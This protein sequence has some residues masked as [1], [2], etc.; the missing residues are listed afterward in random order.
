MSHVFISYSRK[1][2]DSAHALER[3]LEARGTR[4]WIDRNMSRGVPFPTELEHA[5]RQA[6]A[7][8]V[9]WS[10]DAAG[11]DWVAREI[12]LSVAEHCT[13]GITL[14]PLCLDATPLPAA[15]ADFNAEQRAGEDGLGACARELANKHRCRRFFLFDRAVPIDQQP[16]AAPAGLPGAVA[17][18]WLESA[19]CRGELVA[20][21]GAAL[22]G[23]LTVLVRTLGQ[24]ADAAP[25]RQVAD[26]L[27]GRAPGQPLFLLHVTGPARGGQLELSDEEQNG[28]WLD[29]VNSTVEAI[30]ELAGRGGPAL[31]LFAM[32]PVSLG[33]ALGLRL[34]RYQKQNVQLFHWRRQRHYQLVLDTRELDVEG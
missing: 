24:Q 16:G 9:L 21:R 10:A 22:A 13:R 2:K 27:A 26:F 29:V 1:N 6:S 19:H 32:A 7:V 14:L 11:S 5:I 8:V 34:D 3:R 33:I 31:Q 4:V 12:E 23:V 25:L 30:G 17:L 15:L 20:A 18:P 28:Q